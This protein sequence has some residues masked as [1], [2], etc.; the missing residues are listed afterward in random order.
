MTLEARTSSATSLDERPRGNSV[1]LGESFPNQPRLGRSAWDRFK[2]VVRGQLGG[3]FARGVAILAGGSAVGQGIVIVSSPLIARLYEPSDFGVLAVYSSVIS[4][5]LVI[6]SWRYEL[7]IPLPDSDETASAL[8]LLCFGILAGMTALVAAFVYFFGFFLVRWL[9]APL[10]QPYL[11]LLP[12]GVAGAGAYQILNYWA[13]RKKAFGEIARTRL[14]QSIGKVVTQVG[15]WW[16]GMGTVGLLA[17]DEV[18]RAGGV[19]SLAIAARNTGIA[20]RGAGAHVTHVAGR[21]I[22]FPIVT[23][24]AGLF[25]IS[26][27]QLPALLLSAKFGP[28]TTGYY[29]LGFR[30]LGAPL[31]LVGVSIGQVLLARAAQI[32]D[33]HAKVRAITERSALVLFGVGLPPFIA[34][35]LAGRTMFSVVFGPEWSTAGYYAQLLAPWFLFWLVAS[36]LSALLTVREWQWSSLAFTACEL[37]TR[38]MSIIIGAWHGSPTIAIALLS[39]SGVLVSLVSIARFLQAGYSSP[40]RIARPAGRI[41]AL[42]LL[43]LAPLAAASLFGGLVITAALAAICIPAY[44]IGLLRFSLVGMTHAVGGARV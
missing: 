4:I 18:G 36:P 7:A 31:A 21:Y 28:E 41:V 13:V 1:D 19:G 10:L 23:T 43:C 44:Y 32:A 24:W 16:L 33:E 17:A 38:V 29:S 40:K 22:K 15:M 5:L 20:W 27:L 37:I 35:G 2:T 9:N 14:T 25:N 8:V 30:L 26:S 39:G 42:G 3:G 11:W 6:A 12:I 34:V